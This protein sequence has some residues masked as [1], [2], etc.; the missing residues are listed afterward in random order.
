MHMSRYKASGRLA[1]SCKEVVPMKQYILRIIIL[2][3]MFLV[4][5][6]QNVK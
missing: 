1:I 3:V 2:V 4:A 5:F 6:T